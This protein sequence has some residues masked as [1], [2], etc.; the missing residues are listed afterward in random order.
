MIALAVELELFCSLLKA[1]VWQRR[2]MM[3]IMTVCET[4]AHSPREKDF[5][6]INGRN[7]SK[8][9]YKNKPKH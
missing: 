4:I 9:I 7:V 5:G 6:N 3:N 8:T 2:L 1:F